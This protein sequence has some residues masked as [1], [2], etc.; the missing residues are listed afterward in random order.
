MILELHAIQ[1]FAPANLNRD[2]TGAPKECTFGGVRRA[3][4]SSQAWKRAIR[5]AFRGD[6]DDARLGTRTKRAHDEIVARLRAAD[7][8]LDEDLARHRAAVVLEAKPLELKL[9]LKTED[10][11]GEVK[12]G[13]LVFFRPSD[14][15]ALAQAAQNFAGEIDDSPSTVRDG[16]KAKAKLP[17]EAEKAIKA[18]MTSPGDAIDVALFGRMVA[19]LP[20]SN[21]DASCQ[22]A[23]AIGT[24]RLAREADYF[25]AV[26]DLQPEETEGADMIGTVEFNASCLYRYAVL[27]VRQLAENLGEDPESEAVTAAI[28]SFARAFATVAPSGKQNTFAA[29]NMPSAVLGVRRRSGTWN[30]ANAFVQPVDALNETVGVDVA[31]T[32]RM[33]QE[34]ATLDRVYGAPGDEIEGWMVS[35][36]GDVDGGDTDAIRRV[37]RLEDLIDGLV[38][39]S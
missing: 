16:A 37:D 9:K 10:G 27:D 19:E 8:S 30:L 26:D 1:S 21:V 7:S 34:F 33:L 29:R 32:K 6:L 11:T 35:T 17:K 2:D 22:V 36:S 13:Q 5:V 39:G 15:D 18:A 12:T 14:L 4:V 23:H 38:G 31:S 24:H 25:T 28:R 3:R 20:E